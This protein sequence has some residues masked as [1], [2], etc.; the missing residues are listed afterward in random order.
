MSNTNTKPT[1]LDVSLTGAILTLLINFQQRYDQG[2]SLEY[3]LEDCLLT[4]ITAKQRSKDYSEQT[5]NRKLFEKAIQNDPMIV[6]RP[7]DMARLMQKY[8]IGA[9]NAKAT[10]AMDEILTAPEPAPAPTIMA[11]PAKVA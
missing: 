5:N 7:K 4:G 1:S 11:A 8:K 2:H 9:S 6:M 3:V 10:E